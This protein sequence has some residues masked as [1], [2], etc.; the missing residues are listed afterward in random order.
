MYPR[1]LRLSGIV[2]RTILA[3]FTVIQTLLPGFAESAAA[4][5]PGVQTQLGEDRPPEAGGLTAA[6]LPVVGAPGAL[7][8]PDGQAPGTVTPN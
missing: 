6:M 8:A 3:L 2:I 1:R 4:A 5:S 7:A